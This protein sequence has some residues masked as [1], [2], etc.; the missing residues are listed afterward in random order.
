[1]CCMYPEMYDVFDLFPCLILSYKIPELQIRGGI[2]DNSE[3]IF[4]I[5]KRKYML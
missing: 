4:L 5:P 3:I 1:M 2:E